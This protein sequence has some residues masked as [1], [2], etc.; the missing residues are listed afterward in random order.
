MRA[1][2]DA[3]QAELCARGFFPSREGIDLLRAGHAQGPRD[4]SWAQ[5]KAAFDPNGVIAPGRYA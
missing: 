2:R 1:L 5:I 4:A 3:L